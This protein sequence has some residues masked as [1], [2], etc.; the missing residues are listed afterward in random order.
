MQGSYQFKTLFIKC[1]QT[2]KLLPLRK[3]TRGNHFGPPGWSTA[4]M[5]LKRY[6]GPLKLRQWE[7][8]FA[9]INCQF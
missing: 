6:Y 2:R 1:P 8:R 3:L 4:I 5:F 7:T 9:V